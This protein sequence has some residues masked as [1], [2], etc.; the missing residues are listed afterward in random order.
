MPFPEI[1]RLRSASSNYMDKNRKIRAVF[2]E[3][4]EMYAV[5]SKNTIE[6]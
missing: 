2:P 1:G 3:E 6:Y 5:T 4:W